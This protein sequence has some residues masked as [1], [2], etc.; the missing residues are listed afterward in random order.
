[1]LA[2]ERSSLGYDDRGFTGDVGEF[3]RR[4]P[5][6]MTDC[7]PLFVFTGAIGFLGQFWLPVA[8]AFPVRAVATKLTVIHSRNTAGACELILSLPN[9]SWAGPSAA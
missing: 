1:M 3:G 8:A 2:D 5:D 4:S 6:L 7:D 9:F